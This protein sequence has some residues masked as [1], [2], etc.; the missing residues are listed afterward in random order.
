M[1]TQKRKT[2][3]RYAGTRRPRELVKQAAA[4]V[5]RGLED[6]EGRAGNRRWPRSKRKP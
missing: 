3:K 5:E 1:A 4:D 2:M 6:T